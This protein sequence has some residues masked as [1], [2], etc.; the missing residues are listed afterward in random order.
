MS[1]CR[2]RAISQMARTL[3]PVGQPL[4]Q[5]TLRFSTLSDEAWGSGSEL[6]AVTRL[7][8]DHCTAM[9]QLGFRAALDAGLQRM[10]RLL[11]LSCAHCKLK[12]RLPETLCQLTTITQLRLI[13]VGLEHARLPRLACMQG[14]SHCWGR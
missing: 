13:D 5:L 3:I 7:E 6:G 14:A 11:E 9:R 4:G 1:L 10:P 8:L 2:A 12:G